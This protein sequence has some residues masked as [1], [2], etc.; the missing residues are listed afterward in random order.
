M[1]YDEELARRMRAA[2]PEHAGVSERKMFGSLAF[3]VDGNLACC[4]RG[5]GS[6]L[7]RVGVEAVDEAL[8]ERDVTPME[9]GGRRMKGWV[10]VGADVVA[11]DE[12]LQRWVDRC[13]EFAESL[14]AK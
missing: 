2:L 7:A 6:M 14:P 1:A 9:M 13:V 4:A 11:D 12:S 3:M 10:F 8:A 5:D